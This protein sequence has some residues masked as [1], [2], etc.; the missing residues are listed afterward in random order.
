MDDLTPLR[1]ELAAFPLDLSPVSLQLAACI[2]MIPSPRIS[3]TTLELQ[4]RRNS[5]EFYEHISS[6]LDHTLRTPERK[7]RPLPL[8]CFEEPTRCIWIQSC[9][10]CTRSS[11]PTAPAADMFLLAGLMRSR[12][13]SV[14]GLLA[15]CY[16]PSRSTGPREA[17]LPRSPESRCEMR[18]GRRFMGDHK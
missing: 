10:S 9:R 8:L 15:A 3:I 14:L 18:E 17:F 5:E 12:S 13:G 2:Q 16:H 11:K 1:Q 4:G 7:L 6:G